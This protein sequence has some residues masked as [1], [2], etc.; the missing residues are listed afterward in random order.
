MEAREAN[1][2]DKTVVFEVTTI[3]TTTTTV[4]NITIDKKNNIACIFFLPLYT[5]EMKCL[6]KSLENR[7]FSI[8]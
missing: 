6:Y 1:K 5:D 2:V 7:L 3:T 4:T 8:S